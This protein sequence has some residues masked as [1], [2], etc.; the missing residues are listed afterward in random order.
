MNTLCPLNLHNVIHQ[1]YLNEAGA[2]RTK[3]NH[4]VLGHVF[5]IFI[6]NI[7][8]V[9]E[10]ENYISFIFLLTVEIFSSLGKTHFNGKLNY[11]CNVLKVPTTG[12]IP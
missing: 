3:T 9:K 10:K 6:L 1:S 8:C 12:S 4:R 2:K 11:N 7:F 5:L